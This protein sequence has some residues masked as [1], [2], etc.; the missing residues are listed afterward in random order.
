MRYSQV[1]FLNDDGRISYFS[2]SD[3]KQQSNESLANFAQTLKE[4]SKDCS[5]QVVTATE[6]RDN[7]L[8]D[9]FIGG[10]SNSSIRQR[11]LEEE[12]LHF[13]EDLK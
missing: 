1:I 12:H 7:M 9:V 10:I 6:H 3:T 13:Q 2:V 8:R 5:F 4:R 11:L